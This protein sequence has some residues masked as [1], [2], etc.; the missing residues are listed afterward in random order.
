MDIIC[1]SCNFNFK[2]NEN[3]TNSGGGSLPPTGGDYEFSESEE[4]FRCPSCNEYLGIRVRR[5]LSGEYLQHEKVFIASDP[6][7]AYLKINFHKTKN[8]FILE[9]NKNIFIYE[10][11]KEW[12]QKFELK[13]YELT[14]S[15]LYFIKNQK[16]YLAL[17]ENGK[18]IQKFPNKFDYYSPFNLETYYEDKLIL[19]GLQD[20]F[21]RIKFKLKE[22]IS[23]FDLEELDLGKINNEYFFSKEKILISTIARAFEKNNSISFYQ[24]DKN[25]EKINLVQK[26]LEPSISYEK[27]L[28][29]KDYIISIESKHEKGL[30]FYEYHP[31]QVSFYDK[32]KFNL[33]KRIEKLDSKIS[34]IEHHNFFVKVLKNG[35]LF[36]CSNQIFILDS[37]FKI[38]EKLDFKLKGYFKVWF[39][40]NEKFIFVNQEN[41]LLSIELKTNKVFSFK[42]NS[43]L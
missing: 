38:I 20:G 11:Y 17:D 7:W 18:T 41:D 42:K 10:F 24:F 29:S 12:K 5:T 32:K 39:S 26:Y 14:K 9:K 31:F 6:D 8:E 30:V 43:Y 35:N 3:E 34:V 33:I 2:I 28:L 36:W 25:F 37:E 16:E 15:D 19:S 40:E 4:N 22:K 23:S 21:Q 13:N 1:P 27:V